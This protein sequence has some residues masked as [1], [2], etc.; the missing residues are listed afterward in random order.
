M[1]IPLFQSDIVVLYWPFY[2]QTQCHQT[3]V[4][5]TADYWLP[6]SNVSLVIPILLISLLLLWCST[7]PSTA[8]SASLS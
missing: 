8:I 6:F 1:F 4:F 5:M 7:E 2:F 3:V